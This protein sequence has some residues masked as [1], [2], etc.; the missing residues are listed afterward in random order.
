MSHLVRP[1]GARGAGLEGA[2]GTPPARRRGS[3][4]RGPLSLCQPDHALAIMSCGDELGGPAGAGPDLAQDAPVLQLGVDPLA[5]AAAAGMGG[6]DVL[7]VA[8]QPPIAAGVGV[9]STAPLRNRDSRASSLVGGVGDSG[10]PASVSA[11]MIPC[12]RAAPMSCRTPGSGGEIHT[13]LPMGS[14]MTCTFSPWA[15][16]LPE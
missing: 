15:L 4:V 6:I 13:N 3:A 2:P 1:P 11:S 14:A 10:I 5:R 12:S 16:C 8:R 7:L 9:E